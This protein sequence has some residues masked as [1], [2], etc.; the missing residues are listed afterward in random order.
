MMMMI[1]MIM[2]LIM[3]MVMDAIGKA[4]S[5]GLS[6]CDQKGSL[7]D[8]EKLRFDFSWSGA[9][10]PIQVKQVEDIVNQRIQQSLPV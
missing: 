7:V 4:A 3:M 9:L 10:T 2:M 8:E 6:W 5:E 1:M